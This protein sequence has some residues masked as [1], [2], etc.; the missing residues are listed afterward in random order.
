MTALMVARE[1]GRQ[2]ARM[3]A[4]LEAALL[5]DGYAIVPRLVGDEVCAELVAQYGDESRFRSTIVMERHNFGRGEYRYYR[6]PLPEHVASL[7]AALYRVLAPIANGWNERLRLGERYPSELDEYLDACAAAGQRRPTPLILRYR[8]GD[9]N[10]LH[11]DL[12]GERAFPFQATVYLSARTDYEGG[13][14]VLTFQRPRAQTVARSLSFECGD[15]LILANRYRPVQ[16]SRGV[17]RENVRHGVSVVR[18]GERH[19]L[20]LIFHDA[21]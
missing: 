7:R 16:G 9:H 5:S 17:Y 2:L 6:Y 21:T 4:A 19:A 18:A 12:Y 14:T 8:A 15:A 13:E 3:E 1:S 20:G 11:Q 10:A